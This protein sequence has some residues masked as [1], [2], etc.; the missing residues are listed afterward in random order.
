[1][2]LPEL[3]PGTSLVDIAT[4]LMKK[5][6]FTKKIANS[7]KIVD[8]INRNIPE[9]ISPHTNYPLEFFF[10]R[11]NHIAVEIVLWCKVV[12]LPKIKIE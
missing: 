7:V 5:A 2:V 3:S 1:M 12:I 4:R 8:G 6:D 10:H 11:A 9:N